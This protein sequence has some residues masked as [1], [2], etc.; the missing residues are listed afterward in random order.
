MNPLSPWGRVWDKVIADESIRGE[1][2]KRER[3]S[4]RAY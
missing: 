3:E 1:R 2:G 4:S